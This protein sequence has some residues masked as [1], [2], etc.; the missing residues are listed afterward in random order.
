MIFSRHVSWSLSTSIVP[1][2]SKISLEAT[3]LVNKMLM[4]LTRILSSKF[5]SSQA[6]VYSINLQIVKS[7]LIKIFFS[8][9]DLFL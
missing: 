6:F 9:V 2:V 7:I 1:Y 4:K 3:R 5:L 8:V